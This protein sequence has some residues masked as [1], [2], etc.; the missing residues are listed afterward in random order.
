MAQKERLISKEEFATIFGE[1]TELTTP[2]KLYSMTE[3]E[4]FAPF[5]TCRH[6]KRAWDEIGI[7]ETDRLPGFSYIES[8]SSLVRVIYDKY[9]GLKA[10]KIIQVTKLEQGE[11]LLIDGQVEYDFGKL[12]IALGTGLKQNL[13][14][15]EDFLRDPNQF[16][17]GISVIS[18]Q[19]PES[20]IPVAQIR[21]DWSSSIQLNAEFPC[22][23][24]QDVLEGRVDRR[25]ERHGNRES[26]PT[27][28]FQWEYLLGAKIGS[29]TFKNEENNDLQWLMRVT[30][31]NNQKMT[32]IEGTGYLGAISRSSYNWG[33]RRQGRLRFTRIN[34]ETGE[35]LMFAVPDKIDQKDFAQ[36]LV[37]DSMNEFL[38][39]YPVAF[40]VQQPGESGQ[41]FSTVKH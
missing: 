40:C 39:Q 7:L 18:N 1:A 37:K 35:I 34:P 15:I 27:T 12:H 30:A 29:Q 19:C 10:K 5:I 8:S 36:S 20:K 3:E 26:Y 2:C 24:F 28:Y 41:M 23:E 32:P 31:I 4:S 25:K 11:E 16:A 17:A 38:G 14:I 33:A 21:Y 9:Y 6:I 13:M 22:S